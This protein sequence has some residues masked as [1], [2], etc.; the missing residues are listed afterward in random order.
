MPYT[1]KEECRVAVG[2]PQPLLFMIFGHGYPKTYRV[3]TGADFP[4]IWG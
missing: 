4:D 1:V 3:A 2:L